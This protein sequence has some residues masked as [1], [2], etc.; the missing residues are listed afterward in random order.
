M[1]SPE[2][3]PH[4]LGDS[5]PFC[6][7]VVSRWAAIIL[8]RIFENLRIKTIILKEEGD[9]VGGLSWLVKYHTIRAFQRGGVVPQGDQQG[10][11]SKKKSIHRDAPRA[12][13]ASGGPGA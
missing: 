9:F 3:E 10:N 5:S 11:I 12:P 8:S 4:W 13:C 2:S 1:L 7:A 6:Q